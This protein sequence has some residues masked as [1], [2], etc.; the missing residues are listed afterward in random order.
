MSACSVCG[1][2]V[3]CVLAYRQGIQGRERGSERGVEE[4][5][6]EVEGEA[7]VIKENI[8][9]IFSLLV[10]HNVTEL[11]MSPAYVFSQPTDGPRMPSNPRRSFIRGPMQFNPRIQLCTE[12]NLQRIK[13]FAV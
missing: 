5:E 10:H 13:Y 9:K 7:G 4:E 3:D 6:G 8:Q 12:I 11:Y 1:L 2:L